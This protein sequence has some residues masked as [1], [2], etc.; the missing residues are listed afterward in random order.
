MQREFEAKPDQGKSLGRHR[1][2]PT[3]CRNTH[4]GHYEHKDGEGPESHEMPGHRCRLPNLNR[5]GRG[6]HGEWTVL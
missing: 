3:L 6:H 5:I 2:G 1:P 4:D